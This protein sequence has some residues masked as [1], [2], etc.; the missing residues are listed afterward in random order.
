MFIG[1]AFR[2]FRPGAIQLATAGHNHQRVGAR[3]QQRPFEVVVP[4]KVPAFMRDGRNQFFL[5][6]R[7][8]NPSGD[9]QSRSDDSYYGNNWKRIGNAK[10]G[11]AGPAKFY[12]NRAV[13]P[14]LQQRPRCQPSPQ[15]SPQSERNPQHGQNSQGGEFLA[16]N[17]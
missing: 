8:Q 10:S 14:L 1:G 12:L 6:E 16:D 3:A 15:S 7:F 2:G 4:G 5:A 13:E 17:F 9:K 11:Y